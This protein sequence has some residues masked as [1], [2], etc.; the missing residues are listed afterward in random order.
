[1]EKKTIPTLEFIDPFRPKTLP[2]MG[3]EQT[4]A[5]SIIKREIELYKDKHGHEPKFRFKHKCGTAY[6]L[7]KD[8]NKTNFQCRCETKIKDKFKNHLYV[9]EAGHSHYDIFK[10]NWN[11]MKCPECLK[12]QGTETKAEKEV[13]IK[14]RKK[15]HGEKRQTKSFLQRIDEEKDRAAHRQKEHES[16]MLAKVIVKELGGKKK[17]SKQNSN[18]IF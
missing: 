15:Q 14:A 8:P 7:D 5:N 18:L 16:E 10:I 11:A 12:I 17:C 3:V 9:C 4:F 1:M 6:L 2:G 13:R